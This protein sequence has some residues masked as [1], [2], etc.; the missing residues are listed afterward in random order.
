MDSL[1]ST[2]DVASKE[3]SINIFPNPATTSIYLQL[4]EKFEIGLYYYN[5]YSIKGDF[6]TSGILQ[7]AKFEVNLN[8]LPPG[9]YILFGGTLKG[10]KFSGKFTVIR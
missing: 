2:N 7:S 4:S 10:K 9:E 1:V 5:I 8:S 6:I 3:I